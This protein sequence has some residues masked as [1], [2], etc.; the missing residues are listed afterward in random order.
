MSRRKGAPAGAWWPIAL[1]VGSEPQVWLLGPARQ[2]FGHSFA[3]RV[4]RHGI[5]L[6]SQPG[7]M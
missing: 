2:R 1:Q 7:T 6:S 3:P 5:D 4:R